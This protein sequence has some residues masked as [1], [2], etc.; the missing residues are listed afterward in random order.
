MFVFSLGSCIVGTF[1]SSCFGKQIPQQTMETG[2]LGTQESVPN[3]R[4]PRDGT[5]HVIVNSR[6]LCLTQPL[7]SIGLHVTTETLKEP[8][9]ERKTFLGDGAATDVSS[10]AATSEME[11][12]EQTEKEKRER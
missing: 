2:G 3:G 7:Q 5:L 10:D 12:H 4:M 6:F 11:L 8:V 9:E 1:S